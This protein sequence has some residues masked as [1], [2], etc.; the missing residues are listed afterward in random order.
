MMPASAQHWSELVRGLVHPQAS[1]RSLTAREL[2]RLG[3]QAAGALPALLA[4]VDDADQ[5]V[6]EAAVQAIANF[7]PQAVG[8]LTGFLS[9][10]DKYVRRNAIWG[11]GKLGHVARTAMGALCAALHDADPRTASGAAQALGNLGATAAPAVPA[12]AE[13]MRGTNVVLCRLAAKAL[14]Q[15]GPPAVPTLLAHLNHHDPF[16][17]GEAAMA[18]GW[19]GPA[20]A[21]AVPA[22][23]EIVRSGVP[24]P[25]RTA[26]STAYAGSGIGTPVAPPSAGESGNPEETSRIA[27]VTALGRIGRAAS[28]AVAVLTDAAAEPGESIRAAAAL[29]LRQIQGE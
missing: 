12:L 5:S 18:I 23:L 25:S 28:A 8:P 13:A 7:G 9:H 24:G 10:S 26:S 29:A 2:G 4:A 20:A 21:A 17:R 14:S 15:I 27:A 19:V 3:A 16:I 11:L 22:L 1:H 6:R